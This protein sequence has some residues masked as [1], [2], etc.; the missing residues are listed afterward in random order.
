MEQLLSLF[1]QRAIRLQEA[2]GGAPRPAPGG[3]TPTSRR[4]IDSLSAVTASDSHAGD[5]CTICFDQV[6]PPQSYGSSFALIL[7]Y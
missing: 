1:V 2:E 7:R 5:S 6:H 4:A 3:T